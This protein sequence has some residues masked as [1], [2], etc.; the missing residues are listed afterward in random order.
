M[1][2]KFLYLKLL[3][4][5]SFI[6]SISDSGPKCLI[7][8]TCCLLSTIPAPTTKYCCSSSVIGLEN[9]AYI[10]AILLSSC[11]FAL[12]RGIRTFSKFLGYAPLSFC[13]FCVLV[14]ET[15]NG[16]LKIE[17]AGI[18]SSITPKLGAAGLSCFTFIDFS[19]N[20]FADQKHGGK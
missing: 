19:L 5:R 3:R 16:Q 18:F 13:S 2:G 1:L 10:N 20:K 7:S 11:I 17:L 8:E 4:G 14:K 9:L 15:A 12:K 6:F